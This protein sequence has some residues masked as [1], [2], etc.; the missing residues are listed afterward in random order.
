M[1]WSRTACKCTCWVAL[2]LYHSTLSKIPQLLGWT[3]INTCARP[4]CS[5][6][7][8]LQSHSRKPLPN[9]VHNP[10]RTN[11]VVAV[12]GKSLASVLRASR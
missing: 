10:R 5:C 9:P 7:L 2:L 6:W 4:V 11:K 8:G 3:T 1:Y 12:P